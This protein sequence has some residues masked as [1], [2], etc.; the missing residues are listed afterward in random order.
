MPITIQQLTNLSL[1]QLKNLT[2]TIARNSFKLTNPSGSEGK[3][4]M[5]T[6]PQVTDLDEGSCIFYVDGATYKLYF[7][8]NGVVKSITLT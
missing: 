6:T 3:L 2:D 8:I 4:Y 7:K 5:D 1:T